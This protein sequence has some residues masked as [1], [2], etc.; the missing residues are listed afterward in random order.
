MVDDNH[1][2]IWVNNLYFTG[3]FRQYQSLILRFLREQ[4]A[5]DSLVYTVEVEQQENQEAKLYSAHDKYDYMVERNPSLA[6]LRVLFPDI[7]L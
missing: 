4:T 3:V 5:N 7:D 2:R 6:T 1:F